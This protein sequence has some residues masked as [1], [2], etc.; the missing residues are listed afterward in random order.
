VN[1]LWLRRSGSYEVVNVVRTSSGTLGFRRGS[2]NFGETAAGV[3]KYVG[4]S[5][6]H[7]R[8]TSLL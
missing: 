2:E 3:V 4:V 6:D 7:Q 1:L 5:Q 8:S